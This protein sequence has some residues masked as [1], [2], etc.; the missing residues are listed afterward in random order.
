MI[1]IRCKEL[2]Y[3]KIIPTLCDIL[4]DKNLEG[5]IIYLKNN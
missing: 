1:R 5:N 3:D 2:F 4:G